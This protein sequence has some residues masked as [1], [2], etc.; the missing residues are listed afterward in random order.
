MKGDLYW[1]NKNNKRIMY[2]CPYLG[3]IEKR[4]EEQKMV[5]R[6][7][8]SYVKEKCE[9]NQTTLE[10]QKKTHHSIIP[11]FK[12]ALKQIVITNLNEM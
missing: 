6:L 4:I 11:Y 1:M 8:S 3:E 7:F 2:K 5:C 12:L 10:N 9:I